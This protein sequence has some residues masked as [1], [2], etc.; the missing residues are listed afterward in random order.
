MQKT[1][2][3]FYQD[4]LNDKLD[5]SNDL[6]HKTVNQCIEDLDQG[7]LRLCTYNFEKNIWVLHEWLKQ[8]I[9]LFFKIRKMEVIASNNFSFVDKIPLKQWTVKQGVRV[10]PQALVRKGAFVEQNCVLMPSYINI[11][12]Y[13]GAG[14]LV[15]TWATVGSC[16]QVGKN[17]HISGG[18][19]LGGVLEPLQATPVIIEDNVFLG[20]RV[21]VVEG[22][23]VKK[24]AVIASGVNLTASTPII[25]VSG[26]FENYESLVNTK[27][28]FDEKGSRIFK[29]EVPENAVVISGM[30]NKVFKKGTYPVSC[31]LIIGKRS[32]ST[33]KKTSLNQVLREVN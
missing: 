2:E 18:V 28:V 31:A 19:G 21:S 23:L 6:L 33:D 4:L 8:S 12:A 27:K 10:A 22:F 11:G 14:T 15:D 16:A 32:E 25:D 26:E 17:V 13:V 7:K 24:M 29:L 9:L 30:R 5:I 3:K 20:S 1:I